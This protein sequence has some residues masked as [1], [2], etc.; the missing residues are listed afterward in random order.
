MPIL[1]NEYRK[2]WALFFIR[3]AKIDLLR[4]KEN[5]IPNVRQSLAHA[6]MKKAQTAIYYSLGDPEY[7]TWVVR[8]ALY[9]HKKKQDQVMLLLTQIERFLHQNHKNIKMNKSPM[10]L[11]REAEELVN[12]ASKIVELMVE[13]E[14]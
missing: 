3:E 11:I 10:L 7:L 12:L 5:S 4:A 2:S 14:T 13:A 9:D 6:S 8:E 1:I